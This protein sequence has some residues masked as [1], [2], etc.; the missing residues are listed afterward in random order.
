[1]HA[2]L[3]GANLWV[4]VT[5]R[6]MLIKKSQS[7]REG[8]AESKTRGQ[9]FLAAIYDPKFFWHHGGM[10]PQCF[11]IPAILDSNALNMQPGGDIAKGRV[12]ST[13]WDMPK[14]L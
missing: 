14:G 7:E 5:E 2:A 1:M 11:C 12:A 6:V 13:I 4:R 10:W 3:A 9:I 8:R